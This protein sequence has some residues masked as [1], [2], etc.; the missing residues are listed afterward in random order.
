M[1]IFLLVRENM[2]FNGEITEKNVTVNC[3]KNKFSIDFLIIKKTLAQK[4]RVLKILE[5]IEVQQQS[6]K[7]LM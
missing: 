6:S 3:L 7:N 1:F 5:N 2:A 4:K